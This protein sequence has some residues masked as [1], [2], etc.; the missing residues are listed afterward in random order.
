LKLRTNTA[1]LQHSRSSRVSVG[2]L[3]DYREADVKRSIRKEKAGE[4]GEASK[5]NPPY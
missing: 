1:D 5:I 3:T 4:T 2:S